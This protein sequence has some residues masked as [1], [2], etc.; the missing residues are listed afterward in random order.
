[1]TASF[2]DKRNVSYIDSMK[3]SKLLNNIKKN[4]ENKKVKHYVNDLKRDLKLQ[5]RMKN[6]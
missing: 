6:K 5:N 2:T 4:L 1:M 3:A